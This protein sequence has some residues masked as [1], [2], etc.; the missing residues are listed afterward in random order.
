LEAEAGVG[1]TCERSLAFIQSSGISIISS[2][3]NCAGWGQGREDP[4]LLSR[5]SFQTGRKLGSISCDE[6]VLCQDSGK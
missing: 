6:K 1:V 4:E 5:C 3:P 2:V